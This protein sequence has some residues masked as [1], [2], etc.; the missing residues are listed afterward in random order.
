MSGAYE[1]NSFLDG[2]YDENVY[3][4]NIVDFLPG[5]NDPNLWEMKII[6]GVGEW[7]ICLDANQKLADIL[8]QKNIPYWFDFRRWAKHDWPLW[9]EMFPH[10]LST[11][12]N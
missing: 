3:Y 10:Y 8:N 9:R 11:L 12:Y 6:L 1:V 4:N 7:D 5:N 2:Y